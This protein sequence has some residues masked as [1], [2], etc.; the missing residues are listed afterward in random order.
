MRTTLYGY[1][2]E[3]DFWKNPIINKV[4]RHNHKIIRNLKNDDEWPPL[5]KE[6]FAITCNSNN[7]IYRPNMEYSGR[8]IHFGAN[9]KSVEH[10][11]N[12]WIVKYEK[13][14]SELIWLESKVHFQTEYAELQTLNWRVDLN[15]YEIIHNG[16]F[17][18]P[19]DKSCWS[20]ESTW[21]I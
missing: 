9:L 21:K 20:F 5:S 2:E 19:I 6:M 14:L 4:K 8:I 12:E 3:M 7:E 1:I 10:E 17:P 16:K 13:L 15:Q 18:K 11:L